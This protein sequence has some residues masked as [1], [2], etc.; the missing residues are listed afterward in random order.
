MS[1]RIVVD[2][3]N[4]KDR[5]GSRVP[6]DRYLVQ[7]EDAEPDTSRAGNVMVNVFYRII[8]GP[9]KDQTLTDR[10]TITEKA[11]FR[12]VGFMQAIGLPTP[13]K[14][15]NLELRQII[16]K[17]LYVDVSDGEPYNGRVKSEVRGYMRAEGASGSSSEA[18]D[19]DDVEDLEEVPAEKGSV[20]V[21]A[22]AEEPA[23]KSPWNKD[24]DTL[25]LD[26]IEL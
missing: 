15:F 6:E 1:E 2:L 22:Q 3:S 10:L 19:L 21:P 7:V 16:G 25:D 5:V 18:A 26:Q 4:Y 17:V 24:G 13:R 20:A 12:V 8:D 23:T 14:R 11:L 9:F